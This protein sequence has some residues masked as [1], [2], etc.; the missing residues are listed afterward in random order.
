[1]TQVLWQ[2]CSPRHSFR[3]RMPCHGFTQ[4]RPPRQP[5]CMTPLLGL[6]AH[7]GIVRTAL[8]PHS[9]VAVDDVN[10]IHWNRRHGHID[11]RYI[12]NR[13]I[14][15][16]AVQTKLMSFFISLPCALFPSLYK[17]KYGHHRTILIIPVST[18]KILRDIFDPPASPQP[19]RPSPRHSPA[20]SPNCSMTFLRLEQLEVS[21]KPAPH[22]TTS[23]HGEP[24][25][26][27]GPHSQFLLPSSVTHARP[28]GL[29]CG[30][31]ISTAALMATTPPGRSLEMW[32]R[33]RTFCK[34]GVHMY[35]HQPHTLYT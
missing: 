5:L 18:T 1:M 7:N 11:C 26:D 9:H 35:I 29:P 4:P 25:K 34:I 20:A 32:L 17:F 10:G 19:T 22:R 33:Y 28:T 13:Y 21:G 31:N 15:K 8:N 3:C 23:S 2:L 16:L 6:V 30:P 12:V 24:H 27:P 14:R